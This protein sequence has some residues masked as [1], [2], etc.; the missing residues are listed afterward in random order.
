MALEH[1]RLRW[2][3]ELENSRRISAEANTLTTLV[4]A[5]LGL[6]LLRVEDV[7]VLRSMHGAASEWARG[8]LAASMLI[9]ATGLG[10]PGCR[11]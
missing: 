7:A 6:A 11:R 8:L 5:A 4:A 1:A 10:L 9:A 2:N 3:S